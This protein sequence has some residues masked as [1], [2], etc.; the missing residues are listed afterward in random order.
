MDLR[1][2]VDSEEADLFE[3]HRSV[4]RPH[5][6]QIWGWDE[7]CQRSNFAMELACSTTSTIRIDALIVGYVQLRDEANRIYVQ[8]IALLPDFQR[9]GIGTRLIKELQAKAAARGVPV[10]LGVFRTNAPA[11]RFYERLGF[12]WTY[13]T[14]THTELSWTAI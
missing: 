4:F 8:N 1:P 10:E 13:D 11:R 6:E 12:E 2:T 7:R 3:I 9:Q 5:I 14:E